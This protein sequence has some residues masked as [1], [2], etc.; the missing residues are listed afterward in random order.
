[1]FVF[2]YLV[3]TFAK[4]QFRSLKFCTHNQLI[5]NSY[6]R[7]FSQIFCFYCL[8]FLFAKKYMVDDEEVSW[9]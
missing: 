9:V 5:S 4:I 8:C 6:F 3:A 1:M 7:V 2:C